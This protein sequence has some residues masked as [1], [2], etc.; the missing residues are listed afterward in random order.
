MKLIIKLACFILLIGLLFNMSCQKKFLCPDCD[1]NKPPIANAGADQIIVLPKDSA[2]L[3]GTA[4][5]DPDGTIVKYKWAKISGPFSSNILKTDSSKTVVKT[6]VMGVYRFELTVTDNGGLSAKDT[7]QIIVDDPKINQPPIANARPDQTI[8]LPTDSVLL[9]GNLSFDPDGT[10][11]SYKWI[12]IS[13]PVLSNILN[14][15]SS[16]T[17]VKN[18]VMGVYNFE[19]TVTDNGGLSAKDTVQIIVNDPAQPNRPPVANAG[20]DQTITLPVNSTNLNGSN[21]TDP[22][23]NITTYAWTKISGP[24]AF[25]ITNGNVVQT[26]ITNLVRGVYEFELKVTDTGGLF[27]KDTMKVIVNAAVVIYT[28]GDTNRPHINA[29][30]IPVGTLSE[31]RLGMTIASAGN[32]ILFVGGANFGM[33]TILSSRVDIYNITTQTWSTAELSEARYDIAP[34]SSGNKIFFGG[35]EIGDGT[36]PVKTVDIYDVSTNTWSTSSLSTAGHSIGAAA[37]GNKVFFAGGDGGFTGPNRE[38]K[39]DIYDLTTNTWATALLSENNFHPTAVTANN[40]IY[41]VGGS[42]WINQVPFVSNTIDIYDNATNTWLTSSL[43]ESKSGCA[44]ITV[45]NN[46]YWAG[47]TTGGGSILPYA[48]CVV[49]IKDINSGIS[50]TQSL[51]S[52]QAFYQDGGQTAVMKDN[53]IIFWPD[54]GISYNKFDVYNITTNTWSIGV[55]PVNIYGASIISVNNIIYVAGGYVNGV[56]SNQVWKLEF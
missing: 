51:S 12:K 43:I 11:T 52:P 31:T 44:G 38:K 30:L 8:I 27:S 2:M 29:Q 41:F 5:T 53:K 17:L 36:E 20:P 10:I 3:D 40:K 46:I 23:N 28:C 39:V 22:D 21:S 49:E 35:G 54:S 14:S 18:L 26:Q 45:G 19:L 55:L 42:D 9:D 50:T 16:K 6:L 13:G 1:I 32:K 25:N 24:S 47:G 34:V 33:N 15:D 4:S 56:L 37:V 48:S 7:M